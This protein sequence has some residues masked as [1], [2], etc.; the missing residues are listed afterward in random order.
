MSPLRCPQRAGFLLTL[1]L[2]ERPPRSIQ[3]FTINPN[4]K[5]GNTYFP[6]VDHKHGSSRVM[7]IRLGDKSP[8]VTNMNEIV[9]EDEQRALAQVS[10]SLKDLLQSYLKSSRIK[11]ED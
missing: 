5:E 7:P 2:S 3:F 9:S 1:N 10:G 6:G 8:R 4:K 11:R